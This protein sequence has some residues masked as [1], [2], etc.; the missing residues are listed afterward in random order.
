MAKKE[1]KKQ[2]NVSQQL[3]QFS[4]NI[5]EDVEEE[6]IKKEYFK[7]KEVLTAVEQVSD[8]NDVI[9][10]ASNFVKMSQ[11]ELI[12]L[13]HNIPTIQNLLKIQIV[14]MILDNCTKD[15]IIEKLNE[16]Q[17]FD[18]VRIETIKSNL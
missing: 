3:K 16:I 18:L 11:H 8:T 7:K 17:T 10:T 15:D 1:T 6:P 5:G 14:Q 9:K 2:V 13:V 4:K 12:R